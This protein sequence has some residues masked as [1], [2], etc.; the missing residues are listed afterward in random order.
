MKSNQQKLRTRK[1]GFKKINIK[2]TKKIKQKGGLFKTI[3]R[4]FSK[5]KSP[6][7]KYLSFVKNLKNNTRNITEILNDYIKTTFVLDHNISKGG[8][9]KNIIDNIKKFLL[10]LLIEKTLAN[11][12]KKSIEIYESEKTFFIENSGL[13]H[14]QVPHQQKPLPVLQNNNSLDLIKT[15]KELL[16][17]YIVNNLVNIESF[18]PNIIKSKLNYYFLDKPSNF[19]FIKKYKDN[20]NVNIIS[21]KPQY[22]FRDKIILYL[23]HKI[24]KIYYYFMFPEYEQIE[25]LMYLTEY[26]DKLLSIFKN[27]KDLMNI[28]DPSKRKKKFIIF[29]IDFSIEL[30]KLLKLVDM[31]E[32]TKNI[33]KSIL[34]Q[35]LKD[36]YEL[37]FGKT[38]TNT[39]TDNL[40]ICNTY[41]FKGIL[42]C[43]LTDID[44]PN[45]YD[46]NKLCKKYFKLLIFKQRLWIN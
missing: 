35:F 3:K 6:E 36:I 27:N 30:F 21:N 4:F 18:Y 41:N 29:F 40:Y 7:E 44:I 26:Y 11:E 14:L 17:D 45:N 20:T 5:E 28:Q 16:I 13:E 46:S 19:E 32:S 31:T 8:F 24:N 25:E 1:R 38:F 42:E 23:N 39:N 9:L 43:I 15:V 34:L 22:T 10:K 2:K 12:F 37:D 33:Y